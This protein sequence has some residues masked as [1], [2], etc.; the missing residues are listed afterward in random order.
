MQAFLLL[1]LPL[2]P[3]LPDWSKFVP[4]IAIWAEDS[5][6]KPARAASSWKN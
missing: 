4:G 3:P 2:T 6:L 1:R 5:E